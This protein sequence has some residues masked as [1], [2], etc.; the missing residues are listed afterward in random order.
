MRKIIEIAKDLDLLDIV[1]ELN[2][3]EDRSKNQDEEIIVPIVGEFS[4]GK[5]TLLNTLSTN[6]KLE[7]ASKA[8]TSVVYEIY[9]GNDEEYAEVIY[10]DG[11]I[12]T[13]KDIL[14]LKNDSLDNVSLVKIYDKS[15]IVPKSTV[16]VDTPGL[17]S[18]DPKHIEALSKYLPHADALIL[19]VDANQQV[20]NTLL[21]FIKLNKLAH[22]QLFLVI[23]KSDTKT[24]SEI[25]SIKKYISDNI[26]LPIENI[27]SISSAKNELEEFHSLM[28]TIQHS[29]NTII[30]KVVQYRVNS[31]KE[32][33]KKYI[34]DLINISITDKDLE[35][36]LKAQSRELERLHNSIKRL[37][38]DTQFQLEE[39]EIQTTKDFER[40][41][42]DKLDN[43]I[44]KRDVD[45]DQKA[46]GVINSTSNI[47]LA[48]Y[49]NEV[50]KKLIVL[51]NERKNS[52][53]GI[54]LRSLESVNISD[55]QMASLSYD[56]D[57]SS[58]GQNMVK[59]VSNGLKVAAAVGAIVVTAGLA[60]PAVAAAGTATAGAAGAAGAA[61]IAGTAISVADTAT[62]VA[63]IVSN[64]STRNMMKNMPKY[65]TQV[66]STMTR[67]DE[68]NMQANQI[69][70]TNKK[71]GFIENIV[72]GAGDSVLGKPQRRKMINIYMESS[73]LPEFNNN[74]RIITDNLLFEIQDN[75]NSEAQITVNQFEN[76]LKELT[77]LYKNESE[78]FK[79][80]IDT[81]KK[82]IQT[83]NN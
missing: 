41:I 9:F 44:G 55:I 14:E 43:I 3:L 20:T 56:L 46:I 18:N 33:L 83:L 58:A 26:K 22:L 2:F 37:I 39:V 71:Q 50:R 76:K 30:N 81:Y 67:I 13:I 57:L 10:E 21:E 32:Y 62:D 45:S 77:E 12:D 60:T 65:A 48:N 38:N 49:Q 42:V 54:P 70:G 75:L 40:I 24:P 68:F 16:L 61:R 5:T 4:S 53:I 72:G 17:S 8:T 28:K 19:F 6:K 51:A 36:E 69:V 47:V 35:K 23:T 63:S 1:A 15:T 82:H 73:L 78:V 31:I 27:I 59:Y 66:Q 52:D 25:A 64:R 29:K 79:V 11:N 80:K 74:L 7:T 34:E